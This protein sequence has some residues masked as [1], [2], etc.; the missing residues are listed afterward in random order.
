MSIRKNKKRMLSIGAKTHCAICNR[1]SV[2]VEKR[3]N[4]YDKEGK[5]WNRATECRSCNTKKIW[6]A[7]QAPRE[8]ARLAK[9]TRTIENIKRKYRER[10]A[11]RIL[12]RVSKTKTIPVAHVLQAAEKAEVSPE[13]FEQCYNFIKKRRCPNVGIYISGYCDECRKDKSLDSN[14]IYYDPYAT[15]KRSRDHVVSGDWIYYESIGLDLI[16]GGIC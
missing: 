4:F 15:I 16:D 6:A 12:K 1:Q 2:I 7:G 9:K 14:G 8:A 10:E 13:G 3:G 5:R 11:I